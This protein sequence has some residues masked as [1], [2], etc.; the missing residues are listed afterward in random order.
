VQWA[1]DDARHR[2][3][4]GKRN[5]GPRACYNRYYQWTNFSYS[6]ILEVLVSSNLPRRPRGNDSFRGLQLWPQTRRTVEIPQRT[7]TE[8]PSFSLFF[9]SQTV[10]GRGMPR[11]RRSRSLINRCENSKN[12]QT[13]PRGRPCGAVYESSCALAGAEK[14]RNIVIPGRGLC[15]RARNLGTRTREIMAWPVFMVSGPAPDGPSRNDTRVFSSLLVHRF[16]Q[17]MQLDVPSALSRRRP[18]STF[19]MGTGFRRCSG[20]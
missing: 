9:R 12:S 20:I 1:T 5:D 10:G 17:L 3:R 14:C 18:G 16:I 2:R 15:R 4:S 7:A 6:G 11:R 13:P 8:Q 19:A